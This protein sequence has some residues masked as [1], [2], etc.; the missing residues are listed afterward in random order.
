MAFASPP[1]LVWGSVFL[2]VALGLGLA[3]AYGSRLWNA[4]PSSS[5]KVT[6]TIEATQVEVG[7]KITGRLRALLVTEGD[8]VAP[9]QL[10]VR[11]EDEE[12]GAELRRAE[13]AVKNAQAQLSDLLAGAR[14]E[15][16][17]EARAAME[18]AR[19][20]LDDLMAGS[21]REEVEQARQTLRSA[22]ATR[23]W[24]EKEHQ[25]SR[26]LFRKELVAAQDVDRARQAY[27]VAGAQERAAG[28]NLDLVMAGPRPHQVEAARA[29]LKAAQDR[30]N[31]LLAGPRPYQ[32]DAARSQVTHAQASLE[33]AKSRLRETTLTSPISGVVL[34]KNLEAGEIANPGVSIL[35]LADPKDLWLRAYV[36]EVEIGKIK[37]GQPAR[38]TVDSFRDR[39]FPGKVAEIASEAEFTPK[40]VQTQKE[41]VNLVFRIKIVVDNAEGILKPG[42]PADADI[43][44]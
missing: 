25:R 18:R 14:K 21:R 28:E 19:A 2:A 29:Q 8:R 24:T 15:E 32:V 42:M 41:R 1:R 27:E 12:L 6:G 13:A 36:P 9:G 37:V 30:L 4:T 35:T 23:E 7:A 10:L 3:A 44:W 39:T 5:V 34:R 26:E 33:L 40:N 31:L 22:M 43:S 38:I 16:I 20:Q 17:E 11:L